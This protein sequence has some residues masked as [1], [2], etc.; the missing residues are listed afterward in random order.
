VISENVECCTAKPQLDRSFK[1]ALGWWLDEVAKAKERRVQ[2]F[3]QVPQ[4]FFRQNPWRQSLF[5]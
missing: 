1:S 4:M 2:L 5:L 3:Q